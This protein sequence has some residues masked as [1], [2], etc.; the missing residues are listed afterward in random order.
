MKTLQEWLEKN[1]PLYLIS[2]LFMLLGLYLAGTTIDNPDEVSVTAILSIF[3]IQNVY[4][5]IVVG[6][7]IYLLKNKIQSEHGKMLLAFGLILMGDITFYQVRISSLS[8]LI[9]WGATSMY[10]VLALVKFYAVI[11]MLN[12]K[13]YKSRILFLF[14][15]FLLVW[16]SP[17]LTY[18]ILDSTNF[19]YVSDVPIIY[20]IWLAAALIQ[21]PFIVENWNKPEIQV[22][23]SN[24]Y[25]GNETQVWRWGMIF[26]F[27]LLPIQ[28]FLNVMDS[29]KIM[30]TNVPMETVILPWVMCSVYF[31]KSMWLNLFGEYEKKI[32][33]TVLIVSFLI[34]F[35]R[36]HFSFTVQ[37]INSV[38]LLVLSSAVW[39]SRRNKVG[40]FVFGLSATLSFGN[41]I[42]GS[43]ELFAEDVKDV[44]N[45]FMK[46]LEEI[47]NYICDSIIYFKRSITKTMLAFI[48]ILVSFVFLTL[49]F[50]MSV[51]KK[52]DLN[53]EY[54]LNEE[55]DQNKKGNNEPDNEEK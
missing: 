49:G 6:M 22:P 47:S 33:N 1:N 41:V 11:K 31:C 15:S 20:Y 21:L 17:K 8:T 25:L 55:D 42:S 44:S 7:A 5:L 36:P 32:D 53:K 54:D 46:N 14:S 39:L 40:A 16:I 18:L 48:F 10:I 52:D 24:S 43:L 12:L 2:V 37:F 26:A 50:K 9:G 30:M 29:Y 45:S 34:I 28:L 35:F 38:F 3:A 4:E 51:K 23:I 27:F 13:V 19:K